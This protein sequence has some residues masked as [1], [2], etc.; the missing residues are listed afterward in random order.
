MN[1]SI[2]IQ[3]TSPIRT[4][5]VTSSSIARSNLAL[6]SS[7]S[8]GDVAGNGERVEQELRHGRLDC[9]RPVQDTNQRRR[10]GLDC[11]D[12]IDEFLGQGLDPSRIGVSDK[13]MKR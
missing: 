6:Q 2:T 10:S 7:G 13:S 5:T 11:C 3:I 9:E 4:P 1:I 8:Y 12:V